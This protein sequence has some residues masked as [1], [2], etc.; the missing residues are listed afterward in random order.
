MRQLPQPDPRGILAMTGL[1]PELQ[2]A[3]DATAVADLDRFR[4]RHPALS[5][6]RKYSDQDGVELRAFSRPVTPA[7]RVLL[8]ALGYD[9]ST[10]T[11][12][13]VHHRTPGTR[14]RWWPGITRVSQDKEIDQ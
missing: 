12:T 10:L 4:D 5:W 2:S 7:E 13:Y 1:P 11:M 8:A 6:G 3:E 14:F 9:T